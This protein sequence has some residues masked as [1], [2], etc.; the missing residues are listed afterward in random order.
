MRVHGFRFPILTPEGAE[1][2][3]EDH[4]NFFVFTALPVH[5]NSVSEL[6]NF[7]IFHEAEI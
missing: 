3:L 5:H 2:T 7:R 1:C 6:S 4:P